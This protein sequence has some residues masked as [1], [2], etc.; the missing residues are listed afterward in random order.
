MTKTD[1]DLRALSAVA[2]AFSLWVFR[3]T[4]RVSKQIPAA[5]E[6]NRSQK[7]IEALKS[8]MRPVSSDS[9][10]IENPGPAQSL[11]FWGPLAVIYH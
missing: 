9:G 3:A 4:A 2:Q 1:V 8:P 11:M 10:Q 6:P 7:Q 5:N